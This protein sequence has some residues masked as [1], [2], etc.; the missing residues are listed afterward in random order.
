LSHN[1][2]FKQLKTQFPYALQADDLKR[3]EL[4]RMH[5]FALKF[6]EFKGVPIDLF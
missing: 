4:E 5:L 6:V 3:G 2:H 1:D